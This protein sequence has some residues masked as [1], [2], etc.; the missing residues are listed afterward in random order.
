[1]PKILGH[2]YLEQNN[3]GAQLFSAKNTRAQLFSAKNSGA[4]LFSAKNTGAQL[5]SAKNTGAQLF[6]AKNTGSYLEL[7]NTGAQESGEDICMTLTRQTFA[8]HTPSAKEQAKE[9]AK[10]HSLA[11]LTHLTYYLCGR[12]KMNNS[13]LAIYSY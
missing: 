1:M 7:N 8:R 3:T 4:Q 12:P 10:E 13:Y 5:F 2:S 11:L 6:S 9:Q